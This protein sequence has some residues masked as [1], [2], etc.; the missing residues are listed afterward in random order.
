MLFLIQ[1]TEAAA[2]GVEVLAYACEISPEAVRIAAPVPWT[3]DQLSLAERRSSG[4]D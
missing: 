2:R 4:R 3:G 1:R